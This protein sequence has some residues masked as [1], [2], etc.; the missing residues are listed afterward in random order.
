MRINIQHDC[1]PERAFRAKG[2]NRPARRKLS[3]NSVLLLCALCVKT[4]LFAG[5]W[6]PA[7]GR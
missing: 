7:T 2:L 5:R 6:S 1:H 4:L 3:V